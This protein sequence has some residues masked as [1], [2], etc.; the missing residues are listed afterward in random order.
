MTNKE[1]REVVV[2]D[3]VRTP[4]G[5]SGWKAA[6]G[7]KKPGIL[8]NSTAH[9]LLKT[10][11]EK[12]IDNVKAKASAFDPAE[13]EDVAMGCSSQF[14]EQGVN[15][16]RGAVLLANNIPDLYVPGKAIDR[17]CN[18]GLEAINAEAQAIMCGFGDIAIAGGVEFCSKYPLG[19]SMNAE[20]KNGRKAKFH[21]TWWKKQNTMGMAA[22]MV[23][24]KY[25]LSREDLDDFGAWSHQKAVKAIRDKE[26][27]Q[28]RIAPVTVREVL[29]GKRQKVTYV[30]D[31]NPRAGFLDDYDTW[32][33]KMKSLKPRFKPKGGKVTAGNSSAIVDG[34]AAVMLMSR[35]KAD[36]LGLKPM[37]RILSCAVAASE[38]VIMLLGP[39]PAQKKALARAR[40]TMEDMD[41]I[42]PNEAFAS[43]CLAFAKEFGYDFMDPRVNPTGGGISI[44]HPIGASGAIYFLEMIWEM[45]KQ[46]YHY[47]IQTLCGGGGV[48]IATVVEREK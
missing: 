11:C 26:W 17:Y 7:G 6:S 38:P 13:I 19:S 44:G 33:E 35:E 25:N 5:K 4:V 10:V 37:V 32:R 31:E 15:I 39:I 18:A 28:K 45:V 30:E 43:P 34:A 46:N 2:V 40:L 9:E 24:E 12:L 22:E 20:I 29:K 3:G 1:L 23:A 27:Y 21:R 14:G 42:E 8:Y 16:G 48:G 47:G 36:E 41:I